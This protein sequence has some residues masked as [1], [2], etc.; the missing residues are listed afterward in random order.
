MRTLALLLT[1]LPLTLSSAMA[2]PYPQAPHRAPAAVCDAGEL[3]V[4]APRDA[5]FDLYVDGRQRVESRIRDGQQIVQLAPGR[6]HV[7]VTSFTGRIWSEQV[8][9]VRCGEVFITEVYERRGLQVVNSW[10]Q[11]V[12][13]PVAYRPVHRG[14][15][16]RPHRAPVCTA[17]SLGVSGFDN[18]WFD[19][20]VDGVKRVES[21]NFDGQQMVSG[22]QPGR[23]FV[24]VTSFVGEVW[25]EVYVDV[26]C[27]EQVFGEVLEDRGLRLF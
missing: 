4:S 2:R 23:H 21:R 18:A 20:Y 27:G 6:H 22:L 11:Q 16:G 3:R 12:H 1:T 10:T 9:D 5:W 13:R 25:S 19:L 15:P 17:G 8:L 7:R 26:R 14:P 24:R